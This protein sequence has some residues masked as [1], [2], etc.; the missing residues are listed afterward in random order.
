MSKASWRTSITKVIVFRNPG[1]LRRPGVGA[2]TASTEEQVLVA[3]IS[4]LPEELRQRLAARQLTG[5]LSSSLA[6]GM[7]YA[8][9]RWWCT[10]SRARG[11]GARGGSLALKQTTLGNASIRLSH[12]T[13]DGKFGRRMLRGNPYK[14]TFDIGFSNAAAGRKDLWE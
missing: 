6:Q 3:H 5:R 11:I 7:A 4:H 14:V 1:R 9:G 12:A 8:A 10:H 2:E 13:T